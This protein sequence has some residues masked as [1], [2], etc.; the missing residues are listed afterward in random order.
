MKNSTRTTYAARID[1]VLSRLQAAL[2]QGEPLPGL[3]ELAAVA[4]FSPF[5][6]HRVWRALTGEPLGRTI[7]RLRLQRAL[8]L[9]E[10]AASVV[11]DVAL[12]CGFDSSQSLARAVR[13]ELDTTPGELRGDA[14]RIA[15]AR[16]RLA[17]PSP[18]EAEPPLQVEIVSL[19]PFEVIALR[20]R[21][22]FEDL[23]AGFGALFGWAAEAGLV[24][25]ICGLYG[26]PYGDHRETAPADFEFD[27]AIA[28]ATADAAPPHPMHRLALPAGAHARLRH[29]GPYEGIEDAVDRLLRDWLPQSGHALRDA[30]I[31]YA[32]LDDPE[33]VPASLLRADIHVPLAP[34]N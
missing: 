24:D 7:A 5:H 20:R 31:H 34:G 25:A 27:C 32:F 15:A 23:D 29:V 16:R 10:P 3:E 33:V 19:E 11:S 2:A 4:H 28:L 26:V 12:A 13:A 9:L 18:S 8:Q 17:P 30:P 22:A 6:F 1:A 14:G 21:G